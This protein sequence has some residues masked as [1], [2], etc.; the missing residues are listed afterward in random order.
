MKDNDKLIS[1]YETLVTNLLAWI[2][3]TTVEL[4]NRAFP[5]TIAEVQTLVVEFNQFRTVEKPPKYTR[6]IL[7]ICIVCVYVRMCVLRVFL[8]THVLFNL[9]LKQ[10][11]QTVLFPYIRCYSTYCKLL[12]LLFYHFLYT[13]IS[14]CSFAYGTTSFRVYDNGQSSHTGVFSD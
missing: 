5:N 1:D 2:Q 9:G 8:C 10:T 13:K 4:S 11:V 7:V 12:I 3:K 14:N 6:I